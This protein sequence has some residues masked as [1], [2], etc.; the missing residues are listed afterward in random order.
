MDREEQIRGI[1]CNPLYAGVGP[2]SSIVS[3]DRWV[4]NA[5]QMIKENGAEQFLVNVLAV[6][7]VCLKDASL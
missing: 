6:L 4:N 3:D 5:A 7:R 1:L 2:F